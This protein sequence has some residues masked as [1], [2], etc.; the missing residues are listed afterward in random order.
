MASAG[1]E[2]MQD[3]VGKLQQFAY[4]LDSHCQELGSAVSDCVDNMND[5]KNV[6]IASRSVAVTIGKISRASD[7]ARQIAAQLQQEI[8]RILETQGV[9]SGDDDDGDSPPSMG[10]KVLVRRR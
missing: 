9:F 10:A 1:I 8:Q 5:D 6:L 2:Q 3:M 4:G 7:Y